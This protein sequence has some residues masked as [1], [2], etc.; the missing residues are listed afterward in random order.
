MSDHN[1]YSPPAAALSDVPAPPSRLPRHFLAGLIL[2]HVLL[3]ANALPMLWRLL[4][5]AVVHPLPHLRALL[6]ELLLLIGGA[7][8]VFSRRRSKIWLLLAGIGLLMATALA[9]FALISLIKWFYLAGAIL[10]FAGWWIARQDA[11]RME[12]AE[13]VE[14]A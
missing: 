13:V 4:S 10:G 8:L 5:L 6:S 7:L 3:L 1:P 12:S 11:A 2:V 9:W 14:Q